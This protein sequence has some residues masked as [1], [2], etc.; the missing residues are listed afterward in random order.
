ML[1]IVHKNGALFLVDAAQTAGVLPINVQAMDID[2]L[3]FT[4]HKGLLGPTGIGGLIIG[5]K[6][7]IARIEPFIRGGTGS[8]SALEIQPDALPD[9]YEGGTANTVGIAGLGAGINWLKNRG[10]EA[11]R[12]H[13]K[14][15]SQT[16]I[17][18]LSVIKGINVYG[19]RNHEK[20]VAIVSFTVE[21]KHV[22]EL[23]FMLDEE[24]TILARVGLHCA[25]SAHKTIGSFPEGTVRLAPGI[26]TSLE[27]IHKTLKAIEKVVRT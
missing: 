4:G 11:I 20:S 18:G 5:Q 19:S 16:L 7:D 25:P 1:P 17:E 27:D 13:E 22:S 26:F 24:H 10:I 12:D 23:G 21:G 8:Q 6:V 2:L 14:Q 3:A 9:K 15:C